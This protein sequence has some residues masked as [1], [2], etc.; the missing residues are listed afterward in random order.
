V[1]AL[2]RPLSTVAKVA[3]ALEALLAIGALAGGAMLF[4][5]PDGSAFG[6]PV[7]ILE[8]SGFESFRIPGFILFVVN[9]LFPLV[10]A[11][12]TLRRL[13]WASRSVMAVG[14]LLAG[15]IGVE[16]ALLRSFDVPLHGTYLLLGV[17]IA[18]LGLVLRQRERAGATPS[19]HH[20][21]RHPP[22]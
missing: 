10:S 1:T 11:M 14:V 17:V 7:S 13:P 3:I 22:E 9:G 18:A 4:L 20:A 16:V 21:V 12:A 5:Q 8:H 19:H 2:A 6:L 15:W